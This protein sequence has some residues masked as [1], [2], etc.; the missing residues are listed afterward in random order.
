MQ[1]DKRIDRHS[2]DGCA[3]STA[4]VGIAPGAFWFVRILHL[5]ELE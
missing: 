4:P 5:V 3:E 1:I 2:T